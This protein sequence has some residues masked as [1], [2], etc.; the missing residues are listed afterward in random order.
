M[1]VVK[2]HQVSVYVSL[3]LTHTHMYMLPVGLNK[4]EGFFFLFL[5][6][7]YL[8]GSMKSRAFAMEMKT[9]EL[10]RSGMPYLPYL[11][12]VIYELHLYLHLLYI[13]S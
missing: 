7:N 6:A 5:Y 11:M 1:L 3:S 9:S 10:M 8:S 12:I 2:C 13:L 4:I